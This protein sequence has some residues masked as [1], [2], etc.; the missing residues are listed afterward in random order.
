MAEIAKEVSKSL[1]VRGVYLYFKALE[2]ANALE[3]FLAE[4]DQ[5][6]LTL[7]VGQE[8]YDVGQDHFNRVAHTEAAG[9]D[10]PA[11]P[12]PRRF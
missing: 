12:R 10:C 6:N 2:T 3:S 4:C 11:C 5:K 9:P 8:L 1:P 7:N